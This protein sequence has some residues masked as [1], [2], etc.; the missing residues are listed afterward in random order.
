M[1]LAVV[2]PVNNEEEFEGNVLASPGLREGGCEIVPVRSATSAADGFAKG[3][4]RTKA[5]WII[6][7]HQ[8][9]YFPEDAA[10]AIWRAAQVI[11]PVNCSRT[12]FG[13]AGMAMANNRPVR[14]GGCIWSGEPLVL[15]CGS[16]RSAISLDEF[17]V[18]LHRSCL[19]R[20]DPKLGWHLWATDLCLQALREAWP[21]SIEPILLHHNST[22]GSLPAEFFESMRILKAKWPGTTIHTLNGGDQ[23][24]EEHA[25]HGA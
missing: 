2:V 1:S 6:Y 14:A 15:D 21:A 20:I 7:C 24:K 16:A 11:E 9:V 5:D 10:R 19:Y 23:W 12:L 3:L 17:A 8:D 25:S 13:F 22:C 4:Q 18:V